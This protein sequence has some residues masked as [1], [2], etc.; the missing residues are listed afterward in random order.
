[1]HPEGDWR[2]LMDLTNRLNTWAE[3]SVDRTAQTLPIEQI[4]NAC[5][6]ELDR[7]QQTPL[8]RRIDRVAYRD[9][10]IVLLLSRRAGPACATL[11]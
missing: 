4:H 6:R 7:L 10:L 3:P 5:L 9:T 1:M 11:P 8:A 2:W